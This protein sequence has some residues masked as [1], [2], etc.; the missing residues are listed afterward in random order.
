M[1]SL[2]MLSIL[3]ATVAIPVA[4]ARDANPRRGV[5]RMVIALLAFNALYVGYVAWIHTTYFVPPAWPWNR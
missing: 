4:L 5:K 2:A 1:D 3:F